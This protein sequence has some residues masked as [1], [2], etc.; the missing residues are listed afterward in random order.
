M[1]VRICMGI[2]IGAVAGALLGYFGKCSSG[3]CP[4]TA[5]PYRGALYGAVMGA[6]FAFTFSGVPKAQSD[7]LARRETAKAVVGSAKETLVH[8]DSEAD[9][10]ALVLDASGICLVDLFS[11]S[12]PPCRALAPTVSSLADKYAGRVTVCKVDIEQLPALAEQYQVSAVPTLLIIR[13]GV[14]VK[15]L[16]GLRPEA[17]YVAVLDGLLEGHKW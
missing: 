7:K 12:C 1:I 13:D 17:E 14:L 5:N 2:L 4:L 15:R 6:L 9:F 16:V 11:N 3:S 10:K 8:I